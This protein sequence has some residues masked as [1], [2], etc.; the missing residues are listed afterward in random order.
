MKNISLFLLKRLLVS[1]G[2]IFLIATATFALMKLAPGD[3]FMDDQ[4][5]PEEARMVLR[6]HYGLEDPLMTQYFRYVSSIFTFDFGPSLKYPSQ[7]VN[8]I[9][10]DGFPVSC[11][12]GF[13]ALTLA[14]PTGLILGTAAALKKNCSVDIACHALTVIGL[15]VPSFVFAACLQFF[16]AIW[17]PIFPVARWGDL[18]HAVL[19]S[20]A[21]AAGP[22]C[23]ILK[24]FRASILDVIQTQYIHTARVKGLSTP[25]ILFIHVWKNAALP[26]ITYLG[27]VTA[28]ILVGSFI[29]ERVFGI[30]GLGQWFVNGVLNRDY[31]VI[32]GLTVFYSIV[33]LSIHTF[34]DMMYALFDPRIKLLVRQKTDCTHEEVTVEEITA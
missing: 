2:T 1:C 34:I 6:R 14:I 15:S 12:L 11:T 20:I 5:M 4:G 16:F 18:M 17:I 30:P 28:N 26:V 23:M 29:V 33:L 27:P 32:G 24:L 21:L 25:R 3:P 19:P 7:S 9:I 31:A 8:E 22:T 10:K 13:L